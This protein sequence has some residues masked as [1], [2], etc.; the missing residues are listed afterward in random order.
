MEE[1]CFEIIS[2]VGEARS[3]YIEAIQLAKEGKIDEAKAL[4]K[5]GNACFARGHASHAELLTKEAAGEALEAGLIM[6]H[7]EDQLMSAETFSILAEEFIGLYT[8]LNEMK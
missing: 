3:N 1:I 7:A 8:K 4:V 6:I 2:N 5:E